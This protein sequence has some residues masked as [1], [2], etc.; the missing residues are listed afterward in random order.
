[1]SRVLSSDERNMVAINAYMD[2]LQYHGET[3][4]KYF[5]YPPES[6]M[7]VN[8]HHTESQCNSCYWNCCQRCGS[9]MVI[10]PECS[11]THCK[12]SCVLHGQRMLTF[13]SGLCLGCFHR[14]LKPQDQPAEFRDF[15]N[16]LMNNQP[17]IIGAASQGVASSSSSS[18]RAAGGAG[19]AGGGASIPSYDP[20]SAG[21]SSSA[22]GIT[23]SIISPIV[24]DDDKIDDEDAKN[25]KQLT[26]LR[27]VYPEWQEHW[28]YVDD[29]SAAYSLRKFPAGSAIYE[30]ALQFMVYRAKIGMKIP[31]TGYSADVENPYLPEILEVEENQN[32]VL[33][34]MY[35]SVAKLMD[36]ENMDENTPPTHRYTKQEE[37]MMHGTSS[38]NVNPIT[39]DGF[40]LA[41][42]TDGVHGRGIYFSKYT[43][44][45]IDHAND[46]DTKVIIISP[47]LEG[48]AEYT[49]SYARRTS[50]HFHVGGDGT[51]HKVT[52]FREHQAFPMLVVRFRLD[53]N[54][55]ISEYLIEIGDVKDPLPF[56]EKALVESA[57]HDIAIQKAQA[58]ATIPRSP[59]ASPAAKPASSGSINISIQMPQAASASA[60]AGSVNIS[61]GASSG[62]TSATVTSSSSGAASFN[63]SSGGPSSSSGV[64]PAAGGGGSSKGSASKQ[65]TAKKGVPIAS[66]HIKPVK[67]PK[68]AVGGGGGSSS[69]SATPPL[70]QVR[71]GSPSSSTAKQSATGVAVARRRKTMLKL[72]RKPK[73]SAKLNQAAS[74]AVQPTSSSSSSSSEETKSPKYKPTPP[75]S[76][77]EE[78][79]DSNDPNYKPRI[80]T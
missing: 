22:T 16:E 70:K 18:P 56:L 51:G 79:D 67:T 39:S 58:A 19:A 63:A 9:M 52:V 12:P 54:K 74:S 55:K 17:A 40:A 28:K 77:N 49:H 61:F 78:S 69:G 59:P 43:L 65:S 25:A 76:E 20:S 6:I 38:R 44:I 11:D 15:I 30:W 3:Y 45:P 47:V 46:P 21:A 48:N 80:K 1:M 24:I 10:C 62:G 31:F 32:P 2:V 14:G 29:K 23:P 64:A 36:R 33:L 72:A 71:S 50:K 75:P 73:T 4:C 60:M 27:K 5:G 68:S 41:C 34:S 26:K 13:F 57:K 53:K 7:C 42:T 35:K 8:N 37:Y 66:K